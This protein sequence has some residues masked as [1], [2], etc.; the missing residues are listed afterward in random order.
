MAGLELTDTQMVLVVLAGLLIICVA[1][2]TIFYISKK[3][4]G[5]KTKLDPM[6]KAFYVWFLLLIGYVVI[7]LLGIRNRDEAKGDIKWLIIALVVLVL[8]YTI[9]SFYINRTISRQETR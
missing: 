9:V 5:Q 7:F 4:P 1:G 3:Y 6:F 2:V 8:F